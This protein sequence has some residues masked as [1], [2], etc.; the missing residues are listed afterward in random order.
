MLLHKKNILNLL[1]AMVVCGLAVALYLSWTT[2][3]P[4]LPAS[5]T[6][7]AEKRK[8]KIINNGQTIP[9]EATYRAVTDQNLFSPDRK[10]YIPEQ[11]PQE[12]EEKQVQS[13]G[14]VSG[15]AVELRGVMQIGD[16]HSG[17]ILNP[18]SDT[19]RKY[20]WVVVGDRIGTME[21]TEILPDRLL[22]RHGGEEFEIKLSDIKKDNVPSTSPL[23]MEPTIVST[24]TPSKSNA[25]PD[26]TQDKNSSKESTI[27]NTPFGNINRKN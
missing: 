9:V 2:E 5:G 10:E 26:K 13:I 24:S 19:E 23:K 22:L 4:S 21:V 8:I 11:K 15:K 18:D 27:I 14:K 6:A 7:D 20:K 1:L 16:K 17:F 3:I 12:T 25:A